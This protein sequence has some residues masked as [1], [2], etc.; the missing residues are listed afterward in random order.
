MRPHGSQSQLERRRRQ[1][2]AL[3]EQGL[4]PAA[5]ARRLGTTPQSVC[6]WMR[7]HRQGGAD[8]LA[9]RPIPGRPPKLTA[10]Q[11]RALVSCLLK[12]AAALGFATDLWTCPRIA[13]LIEQRYGA[14]YHVDAIPRL[15]RGLGFSPSEART[16]GRRA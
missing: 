11:K 15:M 12:G 3:K 10:R 1:A 9:A 2:V 7:R 14:S 13:Q 8:A 5:I 16:S 6:L 4:G